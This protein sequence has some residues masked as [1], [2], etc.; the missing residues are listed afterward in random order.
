MNIFQKLQKVRV[1]LA[2]SD[3]KKTGYNAYSQ[4]YYFELVDFLPKAQELFLEVGLTGI[5][6]TDRDLGILRIYDSEFSA[7]PVESD[8]SYVHQVPFVEFTIPMG[9]ASLKGC[10]DIQNIGAASTY[11]RRYLYAMALEIVEGD[12]IDRTSGQPEPAPKAPK[13]TQQKRQEK[14]QGNPQQPPQQS[15]EEPI[16]V[17]KGKLLGANSLADLANV[18]SVLSPKAKRLLEQAKEDRKE[19]LMELERAAKLTE[20]RSHQNA[21]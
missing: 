21:K 10:H 15:I 14:I 13:T 5:V 20:D 18:W 3:L 6:H 1:D 4:Y 9:T 16:E 17:S 11:M 12:T 19:E 2:Q 7:P 8:S